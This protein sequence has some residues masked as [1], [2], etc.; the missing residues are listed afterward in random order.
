MYLILELSAEKME[1]KKKYQKLREDDRGSA[2][3]K[4]RNSMVHELS[5]RRPFLYTHIALQ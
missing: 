5:F 2:A 1:A 3:G 4:Y